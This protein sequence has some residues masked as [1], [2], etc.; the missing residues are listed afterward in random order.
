MPYAKQTWV[1]APATTS[2]LSAERLNYIESGIETAQA[3]G[4]SANTNAN[5]RLLTS[6]APELIRDTMGT[7]L[8]AGANITIAVNDAADTITISGTGG[9]GGVDAE[10][11]R[12]IIGAALVAGSGIS[13][14]VNDASDTITFAVPG[15]SLT[16][17]GIV[18]LA[19]DTEAATGTATDRAVTPANLKNL[20]E[21]KAALASPTFT[22]DPKAPTPLTSDNDTSIAT[23]AFVR[24]A[25]AAYGSTNQVD[26]TGS[27]W[28]ADPNPA[29]RTNW[30]STKDA[31][32]PRPPAM[33]TGDIW[34][35]LG[36]ASL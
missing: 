6:A 35:S 34:I 8:V 17:A 28:P 4:E 1:N 23:T 30:Y 13:I 3:T 16:A 29:G 12:D 14:S 24:A 31:S 22:G 33:K 11:V 2:P 9:G 36:S 5:S 10:A 27:S 19:T 21:A 32:A 18:E 20:L 15:A 26:Y 7:A 25:L